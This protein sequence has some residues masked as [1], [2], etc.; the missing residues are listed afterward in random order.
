MRTLGVVAMTKCVV[1]AVPTPVNTT[2]ENVIG[3]GKGVH[4]DI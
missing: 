4:L 1:F 2:F 3:L